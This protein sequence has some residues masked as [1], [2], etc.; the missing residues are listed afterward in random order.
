M[1]NTV[2]PARLKQKSRSMRLKSQKSVEWRNVQQYREDIERERELFVQKITV[3]VEPSGHNQA[4]SA[5]V[6]SRRG[7]RIK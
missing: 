5:I 1:S 7:I 6:D 2:T 3:I 4:F